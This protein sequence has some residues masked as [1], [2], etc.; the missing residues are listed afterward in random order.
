[1]ATLGA[2]VPTLLDVS[3]SWGQDGQP[4]ALAEL[5][6]RDSDL[7]GDIAWK[8][9][10]LPTGHQYGLRTGLPDVYWRKLN[11]GVAQSKSERQNVTDTCGMLEAFGQ[12]D[13]D[14]VELNGNSANFRMTENMGFIEAMKQKFED[15]FF[16]GDTDVTPEGFLG[17]AQRYGDGTAANGSHII[18]GGGSGS[19]NAS[20]WLVGHSLDKCY[21]FYP[22]GSKAGLQHEDLG[23]DVVTDS[24]GN[25]FRAYQDHYQWKCGLA[26]QDWRYVVRIANIDRSDLTKDASAG[27]DV[28]DLMVQAIERLQGMDGV[29]PVF[30]MDRGIRSIL[31]RQIKNAKNMNL[32][33]ET[34][35]GKRVLMLDEIPVH[36]SDALAINEATVV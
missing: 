2:G 30:Y 25:K 13:K 32:S 15:T 26:L 27:A 5:L 24:N 36:R 7:L 19:D 33:I 17:L 4:L 10:N 14:L 6:S 21:G 29:R 20:I 34:V 22:K 23:I 1:M 11:Q 31:R 8:E 28:V 35:A 9:S 18:K 3:R 12:I 16:Y